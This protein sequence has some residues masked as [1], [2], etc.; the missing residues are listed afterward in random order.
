MYVFVCFFRF[1]LIIVFCP[2]A[3]VD[4]VSSSYL[5]VSAVCLAM[6]SL[7]PVY[8][9]LFQFID[10]CILLGCDYCDSIRGIGPKRAVDLIKQHKNIETILKNLDSKV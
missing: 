1:S 10:L 9:S 6:G 4:C 5:P 8:S 3:D 2:V 7:L